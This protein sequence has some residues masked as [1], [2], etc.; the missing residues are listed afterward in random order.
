MRLNKDI[1]KEKYKIRK[2]LKEKNM[3]D[4]QEKKEDHVKIW[5]KRIKM[6]E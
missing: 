5:E 1:S 3:N 6:K 2:S 4:I